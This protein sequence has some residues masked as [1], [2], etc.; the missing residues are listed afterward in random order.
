MNNLDRGLTFIPMDLQTAKL[1]VFVDGSFANNKD[2]SSQIGFVI[3]LANEKQHDGAFTMTGNLIHW[4]S[5]KC[6]QVTRSVLASEICAMADGADAGISFN[7]TINIILAKLNI[8]KI[9]IIICT[10]SFSLYECL[11]KLGTT[12]EKRLM[13]DIMSLRQAYERQEI[14]EVRWI[15]GDDNPADAITKGIPNK[16][17]QTLIDT[18][19]ITMRVQGWVKRNNEPHDGGGRGG[20]K[21]KA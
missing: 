21:G 10:D 7:T 12:K 9:P 4:S 8:T 15:H 13:I 11:V 16:A 17:L 5:T 3:F 20:E 19:T 2:L 1:F 18:N 14:F 6:K